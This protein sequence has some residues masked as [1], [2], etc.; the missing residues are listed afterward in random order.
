MQTINTPPNSSVNIVVHPSSEVA[1]G[2]STVDETQRKIETPR[3]DSFLPYV[4][5]LF[6]ALIT[7]ILLVYGGGNCIATGRLNLL[8]Q[9]R[10]L[11][12]PLISLIGGIAV[13]FLL[14]RV[15]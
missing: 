9:D 15:V 5:V 7:L 3:C 13:V 12:I 4:G 1:V 6:T 14:D 10:G 8:S 11:W 2:V